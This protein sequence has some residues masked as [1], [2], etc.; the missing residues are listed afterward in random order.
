TVPVYWYARTAEVRWPSRYGITPLCT[1]MPTSLRI[2]VSRARRIQPKKMGRGRRAQPQVRN[3]AAGAALGPAG[4][5]TSVS[6]LGRTVWRFPLECS[7]QLFGARG[8]RNL[9]FQD[10]IARGYLLAVQSL[11]CLVVRTQRGSLQGNSGEYAPRTR[12]AQNFRPHGRVGS[13]GSI[14]PFGTGRG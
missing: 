6:A 3:G 11:V 7:Q 1:P 2:S 8:W 5:A 12:I 13:R 4:R 14:A 9:V 10:D